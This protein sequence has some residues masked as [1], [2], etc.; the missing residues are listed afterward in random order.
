MLL[1]PP[2]LYKH[3]CH[4]EERSDEGSAFPA[5]IPSAARDLLSR[6]SSRAQRGICFPGCHPKRSK[7]SAF[8]PV[9][10]S[11]ARDLLSRCHPERSEG[12][13]FPLSSRA[14]RGICFPAVIPSA[15]RD[16]LSR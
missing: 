10:P 15:A 7:G 4:P 1:Y 8:P 3:P 11:A 14:Q 5:V 9:I 6:L 13:A 12:S 2:T 16:L